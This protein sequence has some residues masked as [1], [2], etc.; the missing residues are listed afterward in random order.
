VG[1]GDRG[2]PEQTLERGSCCWW[3]LYYQGGEDE[4]ED[5]EGGGDGGTAATGSLHVS[6][7]V[8]A[9]TRV[10]EITRVAARVLPASLGESARANREKGG[11]DSRGEIEAAGMAGRR[12]ARRGGGGESEGIRRCEW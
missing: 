7:R 10:R 2:A 6:A 4:D 8:R 3:W 12:A 5:E 11:E 9:P 1:G